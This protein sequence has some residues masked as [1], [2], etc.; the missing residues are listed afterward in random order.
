MA[1]VND[2]L[3]TAEG[4]PV[5]NSKPATQSQKPKP[6]PQRQAAKP[7]VPPKVRPTARPAL[8]PTVPPWQTTTESAPP[9]VVISALPPREPMPAEKTYTANEIADAGRGLFGNIS[10]SLASVIQYTFK[11]YGKPDGYILGSEGGGAF[12]AGLSFG[13]GRLH[14]KLDASSRKVFWQG[15][16]VGYD[17]GLQSSRVMIL[18][19]NLKDP[20]RIFRRYGGI[21]GSAYVVG[22]VGLTFHKRGRVVLAP[23]RTGIGLRLGANIGYLKFTP[24]LSINPF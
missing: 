18:V 22:G 8:P 2:A 1:R 7:P 3:K 13:K 12:L 19:Y 6:T 11:N 14:T 24:K 21:G 9:P 10:A 4:K 5:A 17:L 15:P 23:I 20:N 16:T